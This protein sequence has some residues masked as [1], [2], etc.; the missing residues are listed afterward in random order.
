MQVTRR[1]DTCLYNNMSTFKRSLVPRA[2]KGRSF[3]P[4]SG[5]RF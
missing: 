5:E 1:G 4:C 2:E 3:I